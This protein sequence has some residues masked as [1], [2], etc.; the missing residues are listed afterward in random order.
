MVRRLLKDEYLVAGR[1][2]IPWH[3]RDESGHRSAAGV[4]LYRLEV[5]NYVETKRMALVK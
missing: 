2:E 3:G 5:G 4:Y 1:H